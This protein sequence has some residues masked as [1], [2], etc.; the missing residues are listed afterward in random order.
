[1]SPQLKTSA[2]GKQW[3][4]LSLAVDNGE[5]QPQWVQV[6]IF[7]DRALELAGIEKR[8]KLY[9]E[10]RLTLRTWQQGGETRAGL[11]VAAWKAELLGQIGRRKAK[12]PHTH[13]SLEPARQPHSV[14]RPSVDQSSL[15]D[16]PIPF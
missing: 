8:S 11:S 1:V 12:R 5:E 16:D 9:I 4:S 13:G 15:A 3:L 7:G 10:G 2:A 6:A 14:L